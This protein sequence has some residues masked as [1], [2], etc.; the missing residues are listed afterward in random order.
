MKYEHL[1]F[2]IAEKNISGTFTI[3]FT[4]KQEFCIEKTV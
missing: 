1:S 3:H 2:D 4:S